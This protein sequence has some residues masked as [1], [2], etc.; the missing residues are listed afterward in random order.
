VTG[1]PGF[2]RLDRGQSSEIA[3]CHR[4][5]DDHVVVVMVIV[6]SRVIVSQHPRLGPTLIEAGRVASA[7][8]GPHPDRGRSCRVT[9]AWARRDRGRAWR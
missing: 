4:G 9:R 8:L 7:A 3:R 5:R 6:R 2:I 1:D